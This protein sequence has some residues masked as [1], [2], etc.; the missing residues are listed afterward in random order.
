M[1]RT[2]KTAAT[3]APKKALT[4]NE[5]QRGIARLDER[6]AELKAFPVNTVPAGQSPELTALSAAI[7]D[8]L[9]RC[10]GEGSS[11]FNRFEGATTLNWQAMMAT[12]NYPRREHYH[13]GA[14]RNIAQSVALLQE[15]RRS[16][17]EDLL[18]ASHAAEQHAVSKAPAV[19][20]RGGKKVFVVH[21]H[22]EGAKQTLARFLEKIGL[23][24]IIL[25]EQ[26]D[27][28]R[29]II[30]KFEKL[31]SEVGFA[32]VLMTPDDIGGA[33]GATD[34]MSRARQNVVFEL[35]YFSASLG[36]GKTCLLR[37]GDVE[38]PSDLYGVIYSELDSNDGWKLKLGRELSA[39]GLTFDASKLL[40]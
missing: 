20:S 6:I 36:R 17:E 19:V 13:E 2:T 11:A 34:T 29:T 12:S 22:D 40:A 18:D 10:F 5:V 16:L 39:A 4:P 7:R 37:K 32:V 9:D 35:G 26:P 38:I 24:A 30:E 27:Q 33:A 21:G 1:A 3:P 8:T 28:G 23:E 14:T 25:S 31:A 15:A